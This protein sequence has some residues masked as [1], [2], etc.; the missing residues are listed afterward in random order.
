MS[1]WS[2]QRAWKAVT[3]PLTVRRIM[4]SPDRLVLVADYLPAFARPGGQILWIGVKRYTQGYPQLLERDG[5][6]CWT[7]DIDPKVARWGHPTRHVVADLC[8]L[9]EA[10]EPQCFSGVLCNGVFGF[11]VDAPAQ[12]QAAW[13]AIARAIKPGGLLLL[14]W[15]TDR[16]ADPVA[17][18]PPA[19]FERAQLSGL[20]SRRE[21]AGTTHVYDLL[22]RA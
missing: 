12:Q 22:R 15:N 14:G 20:P 18:G 4:R 13:A 5:A 6:T 19:P 21:I 9:D 2:V 11:G 10:L 3:K 16:C 8:K 1:S 7:T 17:G